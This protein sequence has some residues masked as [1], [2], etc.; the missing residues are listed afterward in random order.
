MIV[1]KKTI[2]IYSNN[3]PWITREVVEAARRK[4]ELW[5]NGDRREVRRYQ[6]ELNDIIKR[7]K[8]RYKNK[9]EI[10]FNEH[11][12][13]SAWKGMKII[14]GY[15]N[16]NIKSKSNSEE[17]DQEWAEELN[18]FYCRFEKDDTRPDIIEDP[19]KQLEVSEDEVKKILSTIE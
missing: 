14:T 3:K 16:K 6:V 8:E 1:D 18:E 17:Q 13:K 4:H 2:K 7:S 11:D 15:K 5:V 10:C 19:S 9:I 12:T